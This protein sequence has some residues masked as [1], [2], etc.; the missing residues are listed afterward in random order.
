M[1]EGYQR[2][3]N[4][5]LTSLQT[6]YLGEDHLLVID[7]RFKERYRRLRY[8]DIEALL[9]CPTK[10]GSVMSL[11]FAL[12]GMALI[13]ASL[14]TYGE[15]G[16]IVILI[17][18]AVCWI[19]FGFGI[20]GRGSV[21]FG[22]KTAVQTVVLEGVNT[23]RKAARAEERLSNHIEAI[24]GVL[25]DPELEAA[26]QAR[27]DRRKVL[28]EQRLAPPPPVSPPPLQSTPSNPTAS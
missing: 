25:T 6:A 11:L 4:Y 8:E 1:A 2:L 18:L 27:I 17:L 3:S 24:Q 12:A 13:P 14:S 22:V 7:G 10:Q 20:Y 5:T 28:R 9:I 15:P 16:F 19:A 21:R 26:I 23:R